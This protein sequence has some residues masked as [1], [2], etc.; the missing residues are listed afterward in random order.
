M[1]I[2]F[3][4]SCVTQVKAHYC[5][6]KFLSQPPSYLP[7]LSLFSVQNRIGAKS[8]AALYQDFP[9]PTKYWP[10]ISCV[11]SLSGWFINHPYLCI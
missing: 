10:A 4:K 6:N 7:L 11:P 8:T 2:H 5:I 9:T 3:C 1:L